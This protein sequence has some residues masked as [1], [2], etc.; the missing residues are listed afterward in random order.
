MR[1]RWLL[2]IVVLSLLAA[3]CGDDDVNDLA[4]DAE[5]EATDLVTTDD[6]DPEEPEAGGAT[7]VP[8]V[9]ETEMAT[10]AGGPASGDPI[11]VGFANLEG[12]PVSLPEIR[13]GFEQAVEYVNSELGGVNG[14]PIEIAVSCNTDLTPESSVNCANRMIEED[15]AVVFQGVDVAAD[16]GLPLYQEAGIAQIVVF[17]VS[18]ALNS[19]E[20]DVFAYIWATEEGLAASLRAQQNLGA[21]K[22][23][24]GQLDSAA[25]RAYG[26]TLIPRLAEEVGV[27]V[28]VVYYQP[29]VDWATFAQ[30]IL[31]SDP[32]GITFPAITDQ[33]CLGMV[34]AMRAAGWEGPLHAGSCNLMLSILDGGTLDGVTTHAEYTWA[35]MVNDDTPQEVRDQIATYEEYVGGVEPDFVGGFSTLGF[36]LGVTG[37]E[38]LEAV[39]GEFTAENV[40]SSL[41]DATGT[42][43]FSDVPFDC[44]GSAW[45]GS[46]SCR[47]GMIFTEIG[48]DLQRTEYEW[49][50]VDV[51]DLKP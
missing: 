27:D 48:P 2:M 41:P 17:G 10:E 6:V 22:I 25:T 24:L 47:S 21:E 23:V 45:P 31:A 35:S 36:A 4:T 50:P 28:E 43:F 38:M 46:S 8:T 11:P 33:D 49:S 15:V 20:G 40:R 14:R 16:A 29:D 18:P 39:E 44:D 30:T 19:A 12:G 5:E 9:T 51:S 42:V 26:D 7:T 13:V 32:D 3:S 1:A 37:A 34:P